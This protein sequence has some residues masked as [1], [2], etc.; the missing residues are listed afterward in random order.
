MAKQAAAA[1][2]MLGA[3]FGFA[4]GARPQTPTAPAAAPSTLA[5][6]APAA[7]TTVTLPTPGM[8]GSLAFSAVPNSVDVGPL[9]K[10]YVDGVLSGLGLVQSNHVASDTNAAADMSNGQV[11]IQTDGIV[12]PMQ[13]GA[14]A[15]AREPN[16]VT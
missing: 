9:G 5:P 2:V 11:I 3:L 16:T 12:H 1:V 6:V 10:W 14:Y 7:S 15:S 13:I 4:G 8:A